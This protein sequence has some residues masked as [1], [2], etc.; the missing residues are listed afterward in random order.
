MKKLIRRYL[1]K[2]TPKKFIA[3]YVDN[4][5]KDGESLVYDPPRHKKRVTPWTIGKLIFVMGCYFGT[6]YIPADWAQLLMVPLIWFASFGATVVKERALAFKVG[7]FAGQMDLLDTFVKT[8]DDDG[9]V[10][11]SKAIQHQNLRLTFVAE[12]LGVDKPVLEEDE[13]PIPPTS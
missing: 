4:L 2:L 3:W 1:P 6:L 10:D 9:D 5:G 12:G 7:W 8:L 11:I 13:T